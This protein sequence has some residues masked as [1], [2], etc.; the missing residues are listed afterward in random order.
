MFS[1]KETFRGLALLVAG[2]L[3]FYL[4]SDGVQRNHRLAVDPHVQARVD[5]TWVNGGKHAERRADLSFP[6]PEG[7]AL[8]H[9]FDVLLGGPSVPATQGQRIDVAP[10]P[11]SCDSPDAASASEPTALLALEFAGSFVAFLAGMMQ[12][13]GLP[14]PFARRYA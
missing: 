10:R 3:F 1:F 9:A 5:R 13:V 14:L 8:C 4:A 6:R 2:G 11:G 7:G 12:V